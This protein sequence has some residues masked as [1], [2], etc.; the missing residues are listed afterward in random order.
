M[1]GILHQ[2]INLRKTGPG[3]YTADWHQDW[4]V[5]SGTIDYLLKLVK[6]RLEL[7]QPMEQVTDTL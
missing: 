7:G 4:T 6:P 1:A 5:A 3:T 2:Q